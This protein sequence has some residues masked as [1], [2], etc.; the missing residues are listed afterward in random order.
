MILT[1]IVTESFNFTDFLK[2]FF[3]KVNTYF[4]ELEVFYFTMDI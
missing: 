2:D 1:T 3:R 4:E